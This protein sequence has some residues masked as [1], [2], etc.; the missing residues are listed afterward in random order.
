[1]KIW[2]LG[3]NFT[4]ICKVNF[5][6]IFSLL[7][8]YLVSTD[9]FS[10]IHQTNFRSPIGIPI[11]LSGNFGE[12]RTNHFH[13]GLDIK[14]NG[15]I[16]YRIYAIED[17]FVS[18]IKISHWGYGKAIYV[19][20]PNGLT[21]V[22]AH[23]DHFPKKVEQLIRQE[24]Y[25]RESEEVDFTL[26]KNALY[27]KKGE[28][29]AYSGN[30][31]GSSGP[32]LH[33][34]VRE[35]QT[36]LPVNPQLYGIEVKDNTPPILRNIKVYSL[37]EEDL[38]V[39]RQKQYSFMKTSQSYK[40]TTDKPMLISG[41]VGLG[42]SAIDRY[43]LAQN[44]CGVYSIKVWIDGN[45]H[46][47]QEMKSLDFSTNKQINIH[48]DYYAYHE[49]KES[50]H[51]LYIHP[52]NCLPIYKR[53]LGNGVIEFDDTLIHAIKIEASDVSG[54]KAILKFNMRN[55]YEANDVQSQALKMISK[56]DKITLENT[57]YT[58]HIDSNTFYNDY[59]IDHQFENNKLSI[60]SHNS[61]SKKQFVIAMKFNKSMFVDPNKIIIAYHSKKGEVLNRKGEVS[62]DWITTNIN[63]FG[64]FT[65]MVDSVPPVINPKR[66]N[67]SMTINQ[68]FQFIVTDN[69]SGVE[70][71]K[72]KI[73]GK[74]VYSSYNYKNA[75]LTIPLDQYANLKPGEKVCEVEVEDERKNKQNFTYN[76]LY[77]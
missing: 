30:S 4:K 14:T 72:V 53:E 32:H 9:V 52:E 68:S 27:V 24:Q 23:L 20:H 33:F 8:I 61:P 26:E 63:H 36:E 74:W 18:R 55:S 47:E 10:Q 49:L 69:L 29:I 65:L 12:L 43:D 73:D 2:I 22:Y 5:R 67:K 39:M 66:V 70:K 1:M 46:F 31:G 62:G 48:K 40:L 45:V 38:L 19:D 13:T 77:N 11:I 6:F 64:D 35:T 7:I 71:Y 51:K 44:R 56:K 50:I 16:N 17:G 34:E 60:K 37:R 75:I 25:A 42:L 28:V 76:F 3:A 57:N 21:S 41:K 59:K 15:T 54:N 58:I